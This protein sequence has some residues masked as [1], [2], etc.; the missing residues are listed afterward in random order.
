M[1]I[2]ID[3]QSYNPP[4]KPKKINAPFKELEIWDFVGLYKHC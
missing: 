2:V 3:L 1:A 4:N